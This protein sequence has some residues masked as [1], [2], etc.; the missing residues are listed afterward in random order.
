M[1]NMANNLEQGPWKKDYWWVS[2]FNFAGSVRENLNL[3]ET[4]ALHDSTLRDGE[5]AA[6]VVFNKSQKLEIAKLLDKAGVQYIE[7]GFPAVSANDQEA[8]AAVCAAGLKARITCLCR[9]MEKDIDLAKKCGVWG[10]IIEIPVSYPRLKY[11]FGW[12]EDTVIEKALR[13]AVYAKEQGLHTSLFLIDSTRARLEF[14]ERMLTTV[15]PR[16]EVGKVV[17]VDTNGCVNPAGMKYLVGKAREWIEAPIEV[18]CHNDFGL[19]VANSIAGVEEGATSVSCTLNGLGQRAGNTATEEVAFA[20]ECLYGINTGIDF[21]A[22]YQ[23]SQRVKEISGWSFPPNKP[24]VG[25]NLF[26]WEAGIPTAALMKNP[27]TV[28]PFQPEIFGRKHEVKLG[29]KSGK[30]NI[31]WKLKELGLKLHE[32]NL[33]KALDLIKTEAVKL[34]RTL[35]DEEFIRI[36]KSLS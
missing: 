32:D 34:Q 21:A 20:L 18:H 17:M 25:D 3:P 28:E 9:A 1:A 19:G 24:V 10:A 15:V 8:L 2:H 13:T 4:V 36:I 11:Q 26:T 6:G 22:L 16:A 31:E 33:E 35:T 30:A 29:K 14:L 7:A 12:E 23:V 5:Q 27:H